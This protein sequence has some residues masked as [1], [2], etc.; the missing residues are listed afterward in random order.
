M[1]LVGERLDD[2]LHEVLLGQSVLADDDDL[3]DPRQHDLLVNVVGNALKA[4]E[5]DDVL[6]D[7]DS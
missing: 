6:T 5:P 2:A 3:E 1:V 4:A 7:G